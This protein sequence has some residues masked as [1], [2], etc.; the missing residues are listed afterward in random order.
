MTARRRRRPKATQQ[1]PFC[2]FPKTHW[3]NTQQH[4]KLTWHKVRNQTHIL[5][6]V[7]VPAVLQQ[8]QKSMMITKRQFF[9]DLTHKKT[10]IEF[11]KRWDENS[12]AQKSIFNNNSILVD[13]GF[14]PA[15]LLRLIH[16]SSMISMCER[17]G[18]CFAPNNNTVREGDEELK[19]KR[20]WK[21]LWVC[22][23][24]KASKIMSRL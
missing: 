16:T 9:S 15:W 22:K 7:V 20:N 3:D 23:R 13:F 12:V 2:C 4:N 10:T 8:Q 19:K 21:R 5:S 18:W 11:L 17:Y 6:N 24:L 1:H 14:G